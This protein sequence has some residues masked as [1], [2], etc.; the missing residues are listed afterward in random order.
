MNNNLIAVYGSLRPGDYNYE[1]F[2]EQFKDEIE[3]Y[4]NERVLSNL[5]L[6]DL[7][8]HSYPAAT[9]RGGSEFSIKVTLLKVS[10]RVKHLIDAMETG[11]NYQIDTVFTSEG[12]RATIYLM[13]RTSLERYPN[14]ILIEDGDWLKYKKTTITD[15]EE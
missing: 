1:S 14:R 5:S 2:K 10:N 3:I 11:A 4:Q 12:L 15:E 6:Y 9:F 8:N 13:N 7:G